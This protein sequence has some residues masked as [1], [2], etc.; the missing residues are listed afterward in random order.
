M[1]G[2]PR[3]GGLGDA[4]RQFTQPQ[5]RRG[6]D[7]HPEGRSAR[8][9]H[10]GAHRRQRGKTGSRSTATV[11]AQRQQLLPAAQRARQPTPPRRLDRR[12]HL[13]CGESAGRPRQRRGRRHR[14]PRPGTSVA[15]AGA[16]D[17]FYRDAPR[18]HC[19]CFGDEALPRKRRRA[20]IPSQRRGS[21][22]Q[23]AA[24]ESFGNDALR[25]GRAE[26]TSDAQ[27]CVAGQH[28]RRV[29]LIERQRDHR[30]SEAVSCAE[31]RSRR[32]TPLLVAAVRHAPPRHDTRDRAPSH[33]MAGVGAEPRCIGTDQD[34]PVAA[35]ALHRR[36][37][38]LR[39]R[40]CV[41]DAA[42]VQLRRETDGAQPGMRPALP[43]MT[44]G[45][46]A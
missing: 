46:P 36:F 29:N 31:L 26:L 25:A 13:D 42:N 35:S 18:T 39:G 5:P 34:L 3:P 41:G 21:S 1:F 10:E 15:L 2:Y 8:G 17:R 6:D 43:S 32:C 4:R 38:R 22:D 16:D 27:L 23:P 7:D 24:D 44:S 20:M 45:A 37:A 19:N 28:R 12:R 33:L 30:E 14:L 40:A 11:T 9:L